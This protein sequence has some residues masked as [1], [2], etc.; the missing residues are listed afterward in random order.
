MTGVAG[1][2]GDL[3]NLRAGDG[4]AAQ[5]G[6]DDA[7]AQL[8][9]GTAN[10]GTESTGT[11]VQATDQFFWNQTVVG[12]NP[13]G[14]SWDGANVRLADAGIDR[15]LRYD[16]L[17]NFDAAFTQPM[18]LSGATGMAW[19]AGASSYFLVNSSGQIEERDAATGTL[20][21]NLQNP[22]AQ[23]NNTGLDWDGTNLFVSNSGDNQIY[24]LDPSI[25]AT[26]T[27]I[28]REN[29]SGGGVTWISKEPGNES[30]PTYSG[31]GT[32][33]AY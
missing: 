20:I 3:L 13:G 27:S 10:G 17:G 26:G 5:N 22:S 25:P 2:A 24:V 7:A 30:D 31:D 15:V 19:D 18:N 11:G 6:Y 4:A 12:E 21:Q 29:I 16:A 33:I 32:R 9:L 14:L 1:S 28:M 8:N 23:G